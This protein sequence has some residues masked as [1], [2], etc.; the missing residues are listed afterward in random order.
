MMRL[1][2]QEVIDGNVTEDRLEKLTG[3]ELRSVAMIL[4]VGPSGTKTKLKE[5]ILNCWSVRVALAGFTSDDQTQI[6]P[7]VKTYQRRDLWTF[8]NRTHNWK[9]GN[10]RQLAACLLTWRA[11]C[12]QKGKEQLPM[13]K[14]LAGWD[15]YERFLKL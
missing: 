4:G 2:F 11:R 9:S 8:C 15:P 1:V 14:Y 7:I 13:A 3:R 6:D 12:R 5:R 10:K